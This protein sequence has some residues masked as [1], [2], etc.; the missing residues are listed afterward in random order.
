MEPIFS[1]LIKQAEGE[2]LTPLGGP[3]ALKIF[4]LH[5]SHRCCFFPHGEKTE[6]DRDRIQ[7]TA[8]T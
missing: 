4:L 3:L 8:E 5:V 6:R 1:K 7:D 2:T